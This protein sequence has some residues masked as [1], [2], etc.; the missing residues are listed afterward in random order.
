M[1]SKLHYAWIFSPPLP[2]FWYTLVHSRSVQT[3]ELDTIL[4]QITKLRLNFNP[5]N[6]K[7]LP[8]RMKTKRIW[9]LIRPQI[10]PKCGH[11]LI[12][13]LQQV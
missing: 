7:F 6:H 3:W 5:S 1:Q 12:Y 2:T 8:S 10:E 9:I 13:S 11:S 4:F